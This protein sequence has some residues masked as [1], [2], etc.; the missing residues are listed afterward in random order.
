MNFSKKLLIFVFFI[1]ILYSSVQVVH[2]YTQRSREFLSLDTTLATDSSN[3]YALT[4]GILINQITTDNQVLENNPEDWIRMLYYYSI[5]RLGFADLPFNVIV[6]REGNVYQGHNGDE[7]VVPE[8]KDLEGKYLIGY[9][10]N[11]IDITDDAKVSIGELIQE[12]ADLYGLEEEDVQFVDIRREEP[13][14]EQ[15]LAKIAYSSTN[16][17]FSQQKSNL[18]LDLDFTGKEDLTYT[19]SIN[20][21]EEEVT[22]VKLGDQLVLEVDIINDGESVWFTKNDRLTLFTENKEDSVF[23]KNG[24]WDAF[25]SPFTIEDST[26]RPGESLR[27]S[28]EIETVREPGVYSIAFYLERENGSK[29]FNSDFNVEFE[30]TNGDIDLIEVGETETGFLNVRQEPSISAEL[31]SQVDIGL[32][33]VAIEYSDDGWVKIEYTP[34]EFGWILARYTDKL[35]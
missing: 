20:T 19:A 10:S 17:V 16:S 25:N 2:S 5:T 9:L 4:E 32:Q 35:N 3:E 27:R 34:G 14:Q 33:F 13:T 1:A 11:S 26:L 31:L 15:P 21:G 22:Q 29:V 30:I 28:I 23:A 12:K 6:D 8:L 18:V 7:G 24:V